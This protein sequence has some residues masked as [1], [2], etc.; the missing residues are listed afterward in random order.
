MSVADAVRVI[1]ERENLVDLTIALRLL[2]FR[3][4]PVEQPGN[5]EADASEDGPEAA[6]DEDEFA[7]L[8]LY[9]PA[10]DALFPDEGNR[11]SGRLRWLWGSF[12]DAAGGRG[13]GAPGPRIVPYVLESE[14][15][16]S[17]E[18]RDERPPRIERPRTAPENDLLWA[19]RMADY[20]AT[21]DQPRVHGLVQRRVPSKRIDVDE[22][23]RLLAE[24]EPL[25]RIPVLLRSK[26]ALPIQ[27][28]YDV[29]LF[30][31]PFGLDLRA[32][33]EVVRLASVPGLECLAFRYSIAHGCGQGPAWRWQRY[34]I[35]SRTTSVLL[36]SG[37]Y[38]DD[39]RGRVREFDRLMATLHRHGHQTRAVWFGDL[40]VNPGWLRP[41]RW[42]IRT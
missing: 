8:P 22:V 9:D 37:G 34:R 42:V 20:A 27:L 30:A 29:G 10:E 14:E 26:V 7:D 5:P 13:D 28:I 35:P 18:A 39:T 6:E 38:G 33:L 41:Q 23:V 24:G 11:D 17:T 40:P 21:W 36:I 19:E 32:F 15:I 31:G 3:L 4:V 25:K 2:G 12:H 16:L 1:A